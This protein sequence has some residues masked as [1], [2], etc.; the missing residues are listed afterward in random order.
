MLLFQTRGWFQ[1]DG[2]FMV[3]CSGSVSP[4]LL[5]SQRR[6]PA[7]RDERPNRIPELA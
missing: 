5:A 2:T 1:P 4:R 6:E 3:L 7:I